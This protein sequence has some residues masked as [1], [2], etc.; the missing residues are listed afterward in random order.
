MTFDDDGISE[1]ESQKMELGFY[2][3]EEF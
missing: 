2:W 1:F 3:K